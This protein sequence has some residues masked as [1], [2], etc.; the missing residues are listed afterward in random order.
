[1]RKT[2][3]ATVCLQVSKE[4]FWRNTMMWHDRS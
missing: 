1:M 2:F 3:T 4:I